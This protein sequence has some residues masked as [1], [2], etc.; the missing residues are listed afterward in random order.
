MLVFCAKTELEVLHQSTYLVCDGTFEM[1]PNSA[2]QIYT[3][4]GYTAGGEG[5]PLLWA[6]LPNKSTE[7]YSE[8]FGTLRTALTN[9]FGDI[10]RLT[11]VLIDFELAA[12]NAVKKVFPEVTV[13]GCS[14]HFRQTIM[15]RV[16]LEGM[17]TIYE[18]EDDYPG[19]RRWI[20]QLMSM[21]LL[22]AFAVPLAWRM[23]QYPPVTG[24]QSVDLKTT[25]LA[26]YVESTWISGHFTPDLWTHFDHTGPR[27]TNLAE[28][29]HNSLNTKFG[30]PHPSI[31]SFLDWL[32][33]A[34]FEIQCRVIQLSA[35]QPAKQ[36]PAVYARLDA[37][38]Q[39]AKLLYSQ[40]IGHVFAYL[41]PGEDAW[42]WFHHYTSEY[43]SRVSY[44]VGA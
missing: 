28:G 43:L 30:M 2:Y 17:K 44:L 4:H 20:R 15:R 31:S 40:N 36:K 10:G 6:L 34:Q 24:Q 35:G 29:Y 11:Y 25:A 18:S 27:T 8:L 39:H 22:R 16:Q 26:A 38:I 7:T 3:V 5:L 32:Q 37:N 14:F 1:A 21:S 41:F 42:H 13:K 23:L 19:I 12:I 33:K 9:C